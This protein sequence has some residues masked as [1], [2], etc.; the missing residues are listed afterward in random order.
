M[1]F[2][3]LQRRVGV[4]IEPMAKRVKCAC[5]VA[6]RVPEHA[7][8]VR[9]RDRGCSRFER[10]GHVAV[11]VRRARLDLRAGRRDLALGRGVHLPPAADSKVLP[12]ANVHR[13]SPESS[14]DPL[15]PPLLEIPCHR[16]GR[17]IP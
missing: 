16:H 5:P 15:G 12:D 14:M 6:L 13:L 9:E 1:T 10:G 4:G 7:K 17:I 8:G 2:R 3:A 11:D